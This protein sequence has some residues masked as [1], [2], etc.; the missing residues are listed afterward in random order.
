MEFYLP[1]SAATEKLGA[2][3]G[4]SAFDGAVF[5][6]TGDLGTG[7]TLLTRGIAEGLGIDGDAVT[8]PTFTLMNIYSGGRLELRHF[9]LYRLN[10]PEELEDIGFGE[11]AGGSG[12][13]A[14]E[15]A[16]LFTGELPDEY[17]KVV[18]TR[19]E[20][21]RSARLVPHGREYIKLLEEVGKDADLSH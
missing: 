21:G 11:Y 10:R 20:S 17:L 16:E 14:I 18:L 9:D 8:S 6:L 19:K 15:W 13:T 3:L 7:K 2:A 5:A 1:D 12:V 4:R